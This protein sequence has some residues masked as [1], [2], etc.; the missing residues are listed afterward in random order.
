MIPGIGVQVMVPGGGAVVQTLTLQPDAAAGK[1][2]FLS[3]DGAGTPPYNQRN[4]GLRTYILQ[5]ANYTGLV[6]FDV[7]DIP[8][9]ATVSAA[10]LYCY[11]SATG[12]ARAW[13][14]TVYSIAV[15]NAAW[16]EGASG[17][18][19]GAGEPCWNALAADG[20][21]GV[22]TAWAGAAGCST[23]GTDYEADALGTF[24]GNRSDANGTEYSTAL[25][26]SRVQSWVTT[27][28]TNYGLRMT[29]NDSLGNIGSSDHA[30][31]AY[32]PKLVVEYTE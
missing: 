15:G 17:I 1:D 2:T 12:S 27:P 25:T 6:E 22:T 21:G 28:S 5:Y 31:A 4:Y 10:T 29:T 13:T 7:S 18:P 8:T 32:R 30:T 24:S 20:A 16:I 9:S 23:S 26:T 14:V 19:A 11:Q 3:N